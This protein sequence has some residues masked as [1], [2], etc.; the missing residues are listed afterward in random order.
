MKSYKILTLIGSVL[1]LIITLGALGEV[2]FLIIGFGLKTDYK[3]V[4]LAISAIIV[5]IVALGV[6]LEL[7]TQSFVG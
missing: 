4:G 6:H 7:E 5:Y 2:E 1:G 3:F